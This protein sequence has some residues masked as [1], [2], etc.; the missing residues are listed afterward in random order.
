MRATIWNLGSLT[1][2][3]ILWQSF[4][5]SVFV[6]K[7][8]LLLSPEVSV[9]LVRGCRF[10]HLC[11]FAEFPS[12]PLTFIRWFSF[13]FISQFCFLNNLSF[14]VAGYSVRCSQCTRASAMHR[15]LS[16][17][18][19]LFSFSRPRCSPNSDLCR[20]FCSSSSGAFPDSSQCPISWLK[21]GI[22]LCG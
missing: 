21:R 7:I 4:L 8:N 22:G 15:C 11:L 12:L 1:L 2:W 17:N 5:P 3:L 18:G 16:L 14:W 19:L 6:P 20:F 10:F 9:L 13:L